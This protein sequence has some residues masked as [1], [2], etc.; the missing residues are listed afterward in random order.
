MIKHNCV[1]TLFVCLA[2]AHQMNA[3]TQSGINVVA[4]GARTDGTNAGATT[5]AFYTALNYYP[6]SKII[7]PPGTYAIDNTRGSLYVGNFSG[8]IEFQGGA[9]L[10]F[11]SQ[12]H[13][14]LRFVGGTGA[15]IHG[16][17]G[18]YQSVA[19][20]RTEEEFSF[21]NM[22]DL[23]IDS[24][25][26]QNS[27]G[28]G[29]L[30]T[31]CVRPK[32]S[33]VTVSYASADGLA[34]ANTQNAQLVNYTAEYTADNGL[35]FYNYNYLA[36]WNGGSVKN[37][38]ISQVVGAHGI[39]VAGTSNV[40][41]NDFVI[42]GTHG[43]GI[44]VSE[45]PVYATR[46]ATNVVFEHGVILGAGT[47]PANPMVQSVPN[48][49]AIEYTN[50]D[51]VL[52][53]DIRIQGSQGRAVAGVSPQGRFRF[54][55]IRVSNNLSADA[56]VLGQTAFVE[57]ADCSSL[58]SPGM[59]FAFNGVTLLI[60]RDLKVVNSSSQGGLNR[61]MWFQN[62]NFL[63]ASNLSVTDDRQTPMGYIIGASDGNTLQ[64]GSIQGIVSAVSGGSL[65]VNKYS[66]GVKFSN[67]Q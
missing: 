26:A 67:V 12:A 11:L 31:L 34:F 58:N 21:Q 28:M 40:V 36:D 54:H 22:T 63:T 38:H 13:G 50:A 2:A 57:I 9:Q 53:S 62:G 39:A 43:D 66:P 19:T 65:V 10:V 24:A 7:V 5:N 29:F 56:F 15:R 4:L 44:W 61:A 52:F 23:T 18:M 60:A 16:L 49:Y 6:T 37:V 14:G 59:G 48:N 33:N 51:N 20:V 35:A 1:I 30:F 45:D 8:E 17:H 47:V 3:Q 32:V 46:N 42:D 55:N 25:I 41:V 27:P 64:K